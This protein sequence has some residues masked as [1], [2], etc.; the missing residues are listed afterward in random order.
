[1]HND[2]IGFAPVVLAAPVV[3]KGATLAIKAIITLAPQII[4]LVGPLFKKNKKRYLNDWKGWDAQDIR[5]G[6]NAGSSVRGYILQ[7]GDYPDIEAANI[8]SY[9]TAYG[10]NNLMNTGIKVSDPWGKGWRD[11]TFEEIANKLNRGGMP[12]A[13]QVIYKL[14]EEEK[15]K[16]IILNQQQNKKA[17]MNIWVTLA[18]VGVGIFA[19]IKMKK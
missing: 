5:A 6:R 3:A 2:K 1:M 12:Q 13:A 7:D 18:L 15:Q 17:G 19:V 4:K 16:Q 14:L 11:V 8:V 10:F 9:F